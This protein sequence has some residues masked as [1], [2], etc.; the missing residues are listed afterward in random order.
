M[1]GP[2]IES[3][4]ER[5]FPH[6]PRLSL[7]LTHPPIKWTPGLFAGR[8]VAVTIYPYLALRLK[9]EQCCTCIPHL[10]LHGKFYGEHT[11]IE[12]GLVCLLILHSI[13]YHKLHYV[14]SKIRNIYVGKRC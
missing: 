7:G 6:L 4:W 10:G 12:H 14:A 2:G 3:R 1:G 11:G 13:H 5:D 8:D 9:K